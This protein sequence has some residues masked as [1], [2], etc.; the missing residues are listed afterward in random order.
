MRDPSTPQRVPNTQPRVPATP[1]CPVPSNSDLDVTR[2]GEHPGPCRC[3]LCP[4]RCSGGKGENETRYTGL[5]KK[6]WIFSTV[7]GTSTCAR[8]LL[9]TLPRSQEVKR[10]AEVEL[11]NFPC[12]F[13]DISRGGGNEEGFTGEGLPLRWE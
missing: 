11:I 9:L 6:T 7:L 8:L 12:A 4:R 3:A 5:A 1:S 13:L 2:N 10:L